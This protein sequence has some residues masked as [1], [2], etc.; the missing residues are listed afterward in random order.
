MVTG[1]PD[2]REKKNGEQM[3]QGEGRRFRRTREGWDLY[4]T[5]REGLTVAPVFS[6]RLASNGRGEIA[7]GGSFLLPAGVCKIA[8][9]H[10]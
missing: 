5:V 7:I 8:C 2:D 6:S 10:S 3:P 1:T 9:L 4:L